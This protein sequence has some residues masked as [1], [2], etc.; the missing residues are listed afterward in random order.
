MNVASK[1]FGP[2]SKYDKTLPYTYM[3]KIDVLNG[4]GEEPVY[5]YYFADTICGLVEYLDKHD[6]YSDEV[7]V[8]GIYRTR[9]YVLDKTIFTTKNGEWLQ[10]PQ[11]CNTLEAH[12]KKTLDKFYKGHIDDGECSFDDRDRQGSGPF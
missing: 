3:A 11:L 4:Q 8:A 12:Y 6:V 1:I 10:R 7:I 5:D 2:K 9:E